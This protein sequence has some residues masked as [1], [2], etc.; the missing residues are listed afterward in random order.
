MLLIFGWLHG[1]QRRSS[2][3]KLKQSS[4]VVLQQ[5]DK[6]KMN[7]QKV[8]QFILSII[9]L[10]QEIRRA[11][12]ARMLFDE[13]QSVELF[14]TMPTL[15]SFNYYQKV[16]PC[17]SLRVGN[18]I[19]S[20][21]ML[22]KLAV[23]S[24]TQFQELVDIGKPS[25]IDRLITGKKHDVISADGY[26]K[27]SKMPEDITNGL[28]LSVINEDYMRGCRHIASCYCLGTGLFF[29]M[30]LPS[31]AG[32]FGCCVGVGCCCAHH[33]CIEQNAISV[34]L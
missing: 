33:H 19:Y 2:K 28:K 27:I 22:F 6:K 24:P 25:I 30:H 9:L 18:K 29:Y 12:I 32:I 17:D 7:E 11:I 21:D 14:E 5:K 34:K 4:L 1:A 26:K 16:K 23:S 13:A 15:T 31:I 20:T 10:P 8:P 3:I